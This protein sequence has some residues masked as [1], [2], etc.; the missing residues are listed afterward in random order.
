I[1][2]YRDSNHAKIAE[3]TRNVLITGY[4]AVG[5]TE[6]QLTEAVKTTL[7]HIKLVSDGEIEMIKVSKP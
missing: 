4:G 7:E 2:P 1:Y 5:I 3:K 6:Q